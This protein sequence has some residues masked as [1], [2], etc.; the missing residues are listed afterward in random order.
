MRRIDRIFK[1]Y[2]RDVQKV[3]IK[4]GFSLLENVA[5]WNEDALDHDMDAQWDEAEALARDVIAQ[6]K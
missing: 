6:A 1:E 2:M 4:C 5:K 3:C